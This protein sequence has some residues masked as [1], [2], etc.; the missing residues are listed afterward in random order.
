MDIC[1]HIGFS[2]D[3]VS[4]LH[5]SCTDTLESNCKL[6]GDYSVDELA[7]QATNILNIQDD[8]EVV[9]GSIPLQVKNECGHQNKIITSVGGA[10]EGEINDNADVITSEVSTN[11]DDAKC[12]ISC[13]SSTSTIS[14]SL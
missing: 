2:V 10:V 14:V 8:A 12:V 5:G 11:D 1:S 13:S 7:Y 6:T 9:S 3:D 4:S